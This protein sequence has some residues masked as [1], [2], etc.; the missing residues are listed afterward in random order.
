[1]RSNKKDCKKG[2]Y[3]TKPFVLIWLRYIL[4]SPKLSISSPIGVFVCSSSRATRNSSSFLMYPLSYNL[5]RAT[6][7]SSASSVNSVYFIWDINQNLQYFNIRNQSNTGYIN[8]YCE[9]LVSINFIGL[10]EELMNIERLEFDPLSWT[11]FIHW[12]YNNEGHDQWPIQS[13]R[14]IFFLH[15]WRSF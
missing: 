7:K 15:F 8:L 4:Q 12:W 10:P 9:I 5:F 6:Y 14:I 11:K 1:M 2:L 13:E 3:S